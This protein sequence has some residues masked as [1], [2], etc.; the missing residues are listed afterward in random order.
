MGLTTELRLKILVPI[1]NPS[2]EPISES[3]QIKKQH[4]KY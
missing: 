4:E 1:D 2:E 3:C